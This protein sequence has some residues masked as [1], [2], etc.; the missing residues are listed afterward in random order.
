MKSTNS[1]LI[2]LS[3]I[4]SISCKYDDNSIG[5]EGEPYYVPLKVFME[6]P[7]DENNFYLLNYPNGNDNWYSEVLFKSIPYQR[8]Y[9]FTDTQF[10]TTYQNQTFYTP[11]VQYSTYSGSDSIGHQ[12]IYLYEQFLG[13][14][15][16]VGCCIS[17]ENCDEISFI[18][19]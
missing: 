5:S 13:D 7:M 10:A 18:V 15:L 8:C 9:W 1:I 12:F 6:Q 11:I 4:L 16:S 17:D 19:Y 14:T 3:L 2:P